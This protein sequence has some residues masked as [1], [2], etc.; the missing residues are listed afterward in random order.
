MQVKLGKYITSYGDGLHGTPTYDDNG[1][2][3]FINGNNIFSDGLHFNSNTKKISYEE[4]L[5]YKKDLTNALLISINGSIGIACVYK[6]EP[7]MLGKSVGY[8]NFSQDINIKYVKYIMELSNFK[9][10]LLKVASGSTIKNVAP[11]QILDFE[12][13]LPDRKI[14]DEIVEIL[15]GIDEQIN[16]NNEIVKRLQVLVNTIYSKTFSGCKDRISFYDYPYLELLKPGITPF[17]G[18]KI[19]IPTAEVNG[20]NIKFNSLNITFENRENRANMQP[21][22]NSVWFAKMKNSNKHLC[23]TQNDNYLV[24]NFILS[25]GFCG[26]RCQD[27][28]F[29]YIAGTVALPYFEEMKDKLAHGAT[30]ESINNDDLKSLFI[31]NPSKELLKQYHNQTK[32]IYKQMS[33]IRIENHKLESLKNKLLPLLIN[34]QLSM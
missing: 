13:D 22:P 9:N 27:F 19:Y 14:Q 30:M 26:V 21:V 17:Y 11:K 8:F 6:N 18:T 16:R 32:D 4:Y 3:Y 1:T 28:A 2:H 7:I 34:S 10:W 24:D 25:T 15:S 20:N 12:M 31:H 33:L 29:E 23:L 5:K